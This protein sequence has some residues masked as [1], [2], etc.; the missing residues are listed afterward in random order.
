MFLFVCC[1]QFWSVFN[2]LVGLSQ[3]SGEFW[4][5]FGS[6]WSVL[7][8]LQSVGQC[9]VSCGQVLHTTAVSPKVLVKE[10]CQ[11]TVSVDSNT[12]SALKWPETMLTYCFCIWLRFSMVCV[13]VF[14][15]CIIMVCKASVWHMR[16]TVRTNTLV[17]RLVCV[18]VWPS[19]GL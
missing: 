12:G 5:V 16:T 13:C 10:V 8:C 15:V 1:N 19:N 17:Q 6:F 11:Y 9:L 14:C 18:C 3:F 4:S 2:L 7:V